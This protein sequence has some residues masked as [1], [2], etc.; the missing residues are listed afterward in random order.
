MELHPEV[1]A[2]LG[3]Q[4]D[5]VAATFHAQGDG[6]DARELVNELASSRLRAH[7][8]E[9]PDEGLHDDPLAGRT[10]TTDR[11]ASEAASTGE[12]PGTGASLGS[13]AELLCITQISSVVGAN[14]LGS[15]RPIKFGTNLNV[16]YGANGAGKSS[17]TRLLKQACGSPHAEKVLPNVFINGPPAL[18]AQVAFQSTDSVAAGTGARTATFN[19]Q[20]LPALRNAHVY[21]A[22][23][24]EHILRQGDEAVALHGGL[25]V[26]LALEPVFAESLRVATEL[27]GDLTPP[28][29]DDLKGEHAVGRAIEALGANDEV[30]T[31][32]RLSTLSLEE[33]TDL[34]NL[35]TRHADVQ[36][37]R[38]RQNQLRDISKQLGV[39]LA[40][41]STTAD[42]VAWDAIE[43]AAGKAARLSDARRTAIEL[44]AELDR[45]VELDGVG[46]SA[47]RDLWRA[48]AAYS[49]THAYPDS[50]FPVLEQH[51]RCPL[52]MQPYTSETGTVRRMEAF[53]AYMEDESESILAHAEHSWAE[54]RASIP[55]RS[56]E[57]SAAVREELQE[58]HPTVLQQLERYQQDLEGRLTE[59]RHWVQSLDQELATAASA[60][61]A[62]RSLPE[63]PV[64]LRRD[65][66]TAALIA[67]RD[68]AASLDGAATSAASTL[69]DDEIMR[70]RELDARE[71]LKKSLERVKDA[72]GKASLSCKLEAVRTDLGTARLTRGF[73][74]LAE[75]V[76]DESYSQNFEREL[77]RLHLGP[78]RVARAVRAKKLVA[79]V[80]T[81]LVDPLRQATL[82]SVLSTGEQNGVA[83]AAFVATLPESTAPVVLDDPAAS[84]D[85]RVRFHLAQ[86]IVEL[87]R[88]RQVVVFTHD[89]YFTTCLI[90]EG[91]RGGGKVHAIKIERLGDVAGV[92]SSD[93]PFQRRSADQ[94]LTHLSAG[95]EHL[96]ELVADQ[97]SS[98]PQ[99]AA[100]WFSGLRGAWE[101]LVEDRV[102]AGV[103]RRYGPQVQVAKLP[104][105]HVLT[106]DLRQLAADEYQRCHSLVTAHSEGVD[107]G[108]APIAL[109]EVEDALNA[110]ERFNAAL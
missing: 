45:H 97:D 61:Q 106:Q 23:F 12:G 29:L 11:R 84:T 74:S 68:V 50:R 70:L 86:R 5:W 4:P 2:W 17:Y 37:R 107:A 78:I 56:P 21:D 20:P 47:W 109:T 26:L 55:E 32:E 6:Q 35:R 76:L 49:S 42:A 48:A 110:I 66:D 89:G 63:A 80:R 38:N 91:R 7:G 40:N 27:V 34:D 10:T 90:K 100:E 19:G 105:M 87:S 24:R 16:V 99:A 65:L 30:G 77:A 36:V 54:G 73:N 46:S 62:V 102:F 104:Q 22:H 41:L 15:L 96:R 51:A 1:Q 57:L 9:L 60:N 92:V 8:V 18:S 72:I 13:H 14:A 31:F 79:E 28:D 25:E 53:R 82:A 44:A 83:V 94:L 59:S 93:E 33:R 64:V 81:Q 3:D 67:A 88:E 95:A 43:I 52:C 85:D 71:R 69:D 75:A 108:E 39:Y 58:A 103:V 101:T 98:Y